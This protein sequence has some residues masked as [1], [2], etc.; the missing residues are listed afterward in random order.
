LTEPKNKIILDARKAAFDILGAVLDKNIPLDTVLSHSYTLKNISS[1]ERAFARLLVTTV[2]RRRGQIDAAL[3]EKL[4]R[5][6]SKHKNQIRNALRLGVAQLSF[7]ETPA[8]AAVNGS[9]KL[10]S[11]NGNKGMTGLVNAVLRTI[12]R[13]GAK[14]L[15][16]TLEAKKQ[17]LPDWL[18]ESWQVAY[19][20]KI[21]ISI[22]ES[23]LTE[24]PTDLTLSTS[25]SHEEW[26]NRLGAEILPIG[27]LRKRSAGKI[28][29]I[30]GFNEGNWW[31]QDVAASIPAKL[32]GKLTNRNIID[33]CAAPGGKTA[34][35]AS[36]GANV[37]AIDIST[38]RLRLVKQNM[39][40][41]GL[42]I[43]T[44]C[45]DARNYKPSKPVDAILLDAPCSS[46]GTIRRHPDIPW[47]KKKED[48]IKT[49]L[50]QKE[51]LNSGISMLSSGGILVYAVCSLQPEEGIKLIDS[52]LKEKSN[53]IR[54]PININE[55]PGLDGLSEDIIS[56]CG[57]IR[58]LPCHFAKKGGMDGF[59]IARLQKL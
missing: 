2:L 14:A 35:L 42:S 24:P 23:H 47:L 48:L 16:N 46:T 58:T 56:P 11:D 17:N 10:V 40:R 25:S 49:S 31:V 4:T 41:L 9:V 8:H 13:E 30:D 18:L 1:R 20:E 22:I 3:D 43:Q 6:L 34:Q 15:S 38:E 54:S 27:S 33:L 52:F 21:T 39:D 28:T 53:I 32:F 12:D 50:L 19:G 44:V 59:Y 26:A 57:D 7:L 37:I 5:K 55:C 29:E 51:L 36:A 45:A